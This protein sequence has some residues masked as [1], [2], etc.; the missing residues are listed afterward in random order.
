MDKKDRIIARQAR[1]IQKQKEKL[2][3]QAQEIR[4]LKKQIKQRD[5]LQERLSKLEKN[6][7]NSSKPPSS[8]IVKPPKVPLP[9]GEKRSPGGQPGHK[10]YVRSLFTKE[11]IDQIIDIDPEESN[12]YCSCGNNL[13]PSDKEPRFFQQVELYG[14]GIQITQYQMRA[15]KCPKCGQIHYGKLSDAVQRAGLFGPQLQ[16]VVVYMKGRGHLS[17]TTI[18]AFFCDIYH[19]PVS[20]GYLYKVLK[21]CSQSLEGPYEELAKAMTEEAIVHADE[22]GLHLKGALCWAWVFASVYL[23]I[24]VISSSRGSQ[25]LEDFFGNKFNGILC[26]D[27]WSAYKKYLKSGTKVQFCWAHLIRDIRFLTTLNDPEAVAYGNQLL[28][29]TQDIFHLIH[30]EGIEQ[31]R[32]IWDLHTLEEHFLQAALENVPENKFC[33]NMANR[34]IYYRDCYF[35]FVVEPAVPPTNNLAEQQIRPIAID[36]YITHGC[37]SEDGQHLAERVWTVLATCKQ[38]GR[39]VL[40]FLREC[41]TASICGTKAP[42]LL[43]N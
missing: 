29:I 5:V 32:K 34:F 22:T 41:I 18:Q 38:Q 12:Q 39:D 1:T 7:S 35:R 40:Y 24:F 17:L 25:V 36:R 2:A 9:D 28:K 10:R 13:E 42:S 27:L 43:S 8:D 19:I 26:C 33:Q 6:S 4:A 37:G 11:N 30:Q 15:W 3:V 20:I 23:T 31:Y 21:R 14:K 16:A